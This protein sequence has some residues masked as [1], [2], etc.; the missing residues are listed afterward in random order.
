[1]ADRIA[2]SGHLRTGSS[3]ITFDSITV[4]SLRL[5]SLIAGRVAKLVI[6][7]P[8]SIVR[9]SV[10]AALECLYQSNYIV[11]S[12]TKKVLLMTDYTSQAKAF[13]REL[14][15]G[16]CPISGIFGSLSGSLRSKKSSRS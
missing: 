11:A 1:M 5:I 9:L 15:V 14:H 3:S 10:L 8:S 4:E 6:F 7:Y 16:D 2:A 13:Y 12:N